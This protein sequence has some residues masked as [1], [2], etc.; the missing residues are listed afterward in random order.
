MVVRCIVPVD[1]QITRSGDRCTVSVLLDALIEWT[2]RQCNK[3]QRNRKCMVSSDRYI[4]QIRNGK[5]TALGESNSDRRPV[6]GVVFVAADLQCS[7]V[8]V[9]SRARLAVS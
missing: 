9:Y 8:I 5:A 7:L 4:F 6:S 3:C 1:L 2:W